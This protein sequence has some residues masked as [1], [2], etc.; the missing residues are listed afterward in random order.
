MRVKLSLNCLQYLRIAIYLHFVGYFS[1]FILEQIYGI[2]ISIDLRRNKMIL[3]KTEKSSL[4]LLSFVLKGI[5]LLRWCKF[6]NCKY[7]YHGLLNFTSKTGC[8]SFSIFSPHDID[9]IFLKVLSIH[10][11]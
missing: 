5:D 1:E 10:R 4:T 11:I 7:Y 6:V 8:V 2:F 3:H 9:D